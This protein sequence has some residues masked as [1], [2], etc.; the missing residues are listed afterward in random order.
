MSADFEFKKKKID[1]CPKI[2]EN[3]LEDQWYDGTVHPTDY[4]Q[5]LV[6]TML[7]PSVVVG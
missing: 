2:Y 5:M 3:S 6:Q 1:F 7:F 4:M